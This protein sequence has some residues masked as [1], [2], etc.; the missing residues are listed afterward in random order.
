VA[1]DLK[2]SFRQRLRVPLAAQPLQALFD[3]PVY[4]FGHRFSSQARQLLGLAMRS[5]VLDIQAHGSH[6]ENLED[7]VW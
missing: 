4:G 6:P 7:R 5:F 2:E 3:R 1:P